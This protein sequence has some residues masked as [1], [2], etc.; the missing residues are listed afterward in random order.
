MAEGVAE[1]AAG[2]TKHQE[3]R[4]KVLGDRESQEPR[5]FPV[6]SSTG[7]ELVHGSVS[8]NGPIG[9]CYRHRIITRTFFCSKNNFRSR[10]RNVTHRFGTALHAKI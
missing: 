3:G 6:P 4:P 2:V 1:V 5:T 9:P 10:P 7:E 8:L